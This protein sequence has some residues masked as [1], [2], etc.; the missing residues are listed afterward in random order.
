VINNDAPGFAR[1]RSACVTTPASTFP[2]YRRLMR[3]SLAKSWSAPACRRHYRAS[4]VGFVNGSTVAVF[5]VQKRDQTSMS[6]RRF[7]KASLRR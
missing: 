7:A 5:V 6:L 3:C 1:L 4:T 2:V